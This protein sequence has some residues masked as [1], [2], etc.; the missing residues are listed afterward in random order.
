MLLLHYTEIYELPNYLFEKNLLLEFIWLSNSNIH[1]IGTELFQNLTNLDE[2][3]LSFNKIASLQ[4]GMFINNNKL[5]KLTFK[6]NLITSVDCCQMCGVPIT[7]HIDYNKE[8]EKD[9][10]LQCECDNTICQFPNGG[11]INLSSCFPQSTNICPNYFFNS[12]NNIKISK[13]IFIF[14]IVLSIVFSIILSF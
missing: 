1:V 12:A 2:L 6:N 4:N 8:T 9:T 14:S 13:F 5:K 10:H 3:L 11:S 7:T